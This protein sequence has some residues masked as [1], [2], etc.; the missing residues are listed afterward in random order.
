MRLT[1][2]MCATDADAT[3]TAAHYC[4]GHDVLPPIGRM[5]DMGLAIGTCR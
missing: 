4:I 1:A 2:A 3:V 5:G